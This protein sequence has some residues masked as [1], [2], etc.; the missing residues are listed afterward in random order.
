MEAELAKKMER[1]RIRTAP[2]QELIIKALAEDYPSKLHDRESFLKS[3]SLKRALESASVDGGAAPHAVKKSLLRAKSGALRQVLV[4]Y[5]LHPRVM[6]PEMG[7]V[8]ISVSIASLNQEREIWLKTGG[9]EWIASRTRWARSKVG[10]EPKLANAE[11]SQEL[12]LQRI[13]LSAKHWLAQESRAD[14]SSRL[15]L[16]VLDA[17]IVHGS[18]SFDMLL[19][20][21]YRELAHFTRFVREVVQR[22]QHV[23]STQTLQVPYRI[24]FPVLP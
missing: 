6:L 20:I 15:Q 22:T 5:Q 3:D 11:P 21:L 19:T 24:G 9:Q 8:A 17:S 2:S 18:G 23:N 7:M 14:A 16:L 1:T 4:P 12:V 13:I 10:Q